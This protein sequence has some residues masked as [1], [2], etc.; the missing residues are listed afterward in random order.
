PREGAPATLAG[1][2]PSRAK[3]LL[4]HAPPGDVSCDGATRALVRCGA[5]F[6]P[7]GL[8]TKNGVIEDID[9][10]MVLPPPTAYPP[11]AQTP[12]GHTPPSPIPAHSMPDAGMLGRDAELSLLID[13][14]ETAQSGEGQVV[15]LTGDAGIGKSRLVRALIGSVARSGGSV[16]TLQCSAHHER[17]PFYPILRQVERAAGVHPSDEPSGA[18]QKLSDAFAAQSPFERTALSDA[19]NITGHITD[20][21]P[22]AADLLSPTQQRHVLR[23]LI[24]ERITRQSRKAPHLIV[25]EDAHWID[26]SSEDILSLVAGEASKL[27]LMLLVTHRGHPQA[28]YAQSA[29]ATTMRLSRLKKADADALAA[30]TLGEGVDAD[31]RAIVVERAGGNPLHIEEL[32]KAVRDL[33]VGAGVVPPSLQFSFLARLDAMDEEREVAEVCSLIARPVTSAI[34][35]RVLSRTADTVE[36]DLETLVDRQVMLRVLSGD[37]TAFEIRHALLM[38]VVRASIIKPRKRALHRQ[39]A[40]ALEEVVP[41]IRQSEPETLAFHLE[42]AGLSGEAIPLW[43]SAGDRAAMADAAPEARAHFEEALQ[44]LLAVQSLKERETYEMAARLGL[45][46][47]LTKEEGYQGA[48]G[49]HFARAAELS[50]RHGDRIHQVRTL[51]GLWRFSSWTGD[52]PQRRVLAAELSTV[53]QDLSPTAGG[54]LGHYAMAITAFTGGELIAARDNLLAT[55]H[56]YETGAGANQLPRLGQDPHITARAVLPIAEWLCGNL[57]A[58]AAGLA[59]AA[60]KAEA[61]AASEAALTVGLFTAIRHHMD[62]APAAAG[63]SVDRALDLA[64]QQSY[65]AWL[66][67]C[68]MVKGWQLVSTGK[69]AQGLALMEENAAW[70]LKTA[71]LWTLPY[72]LERLGKARLAAGDPN[73]AVAGLEEAIALTHRTEEHWWRAELHRT[74]AAAQSAAGANADVVGASLSEAVKV[75]ARQGARSLELR[76]LKDQALHYRKNGE[77]ERAATIDVDIAARFAGSLP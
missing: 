65:C 16:M 7:L 66:P 6:E 70:C 38:D 27:P 48:V 56:I 57:E 45:A 67:H 8:R 64:K 72:H 10:F 55:I 36:R 28:A 43:L 73:M 19:F 5:G 69:V 35:Q 75:A 20:L 68:Q 44:G 77:L 40:D 1:P 23:R 11:A 54:V 74:L 12:T 58:S 47:A 32:G 33:G 25:C 17:S 9:A 61:M 49:E 31:A 14:W 18:L 29:A 62:D 22:H 30:R 34:L 39:I 24:V 21:D 4:A 37:G 59:T 2:T 76:A 3:S 15:V 63:P 46:T 52:G 51:F 26:P 60:R 41:H 53:S 50:R 71:S 42:E 13:R